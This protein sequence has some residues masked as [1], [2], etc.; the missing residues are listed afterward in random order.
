MKIIIVIFLLVLSGTACDN[1][2]REEAEIEGTISFNL[3]GEAFEFIKYDESSTT[4]NDPFGAAVCQVVTQSDNTI[5]QIFGKRFI[6]SEIEEI[7]ISIPYQ[8]TGSWDENFYDPDIGSANL[9]RFLFLSAAFSS[10][11]ARA[12]YSYRYKG[13]DFDISVASFGGNGGRITGTFEGILLLHEKDQ[14]ENWVLPTGELASIPVSQ[15]S[16]DVKIYYIN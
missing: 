14:E 5:T 12:D 15:G 4:S 7:V 1:A 13:A 6:G 11:Y 2:A 8:T 3:D 10:Q 9:P 16:F